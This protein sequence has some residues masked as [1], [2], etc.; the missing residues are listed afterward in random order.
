MQILLV[1]DDQ[2]FAGAIKHGLMENG[3]CVTVVSQYL[4]EEATALQNKFE[5]IILDLAVSEQSG[6]S[7]CEALRRRG[8]QTPIFLLGQIEDVE[9][10]ILGLDLGANDYLLKPFDAPEL[11]ARIRVALS[12][13]GHPFAV[14][15]KARD[16]VLDPIT[17]KVRRGGDEVELTPKEYTLLE[18]M[19][20]HPGRALSREV[21][22]DQ[23]WNYGFDTGTNVIDVYINYLRRKIDSN[24]ENPMIETVRGVGYALQPN[25]Y[26]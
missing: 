17:R 23:V 12:R 3:F 24:A 14:H 18:Y 2:Q 4:V 8:L 9:D 6:L 15:L 5:L 26:V 1:A 22:R 20:R 13:K 10:C 25:G 11:C 19:M 7:V 21:L 16:L